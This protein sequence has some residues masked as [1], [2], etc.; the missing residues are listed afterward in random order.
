MKRVL[1]TLLTIMSL[2][3]GCEKEIIQPKPS[4]AIESTTIEKA[5]TKRK[6]YC[7]W[8]ASDGQTIIAHGTK[9]VSTGDECGRG[10]Y[11]TATLG[12]SQNPK[13][14]VFPDMTLEEFIDLT[15]TQEGVNYLYSRGV[16]DVE[17][18]GE[19]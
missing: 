18:D 9:C 8:L 1:V 12:N 3:V 13:S 17:V 11:C 7:N 14:L 15:K 2:S 10:P 4:V 5:Q 6:L 19:E 16:H